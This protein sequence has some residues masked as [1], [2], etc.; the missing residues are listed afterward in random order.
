MCGRVGRS[1]L[2]AMCFN[3]FSYDYI[4]ASCMSI[5]LYCITKRQLYSTGSWTQDY[6]LIH[7]GMKNARETSRLEI[8][9]YNNITRRVCVINYYHTSTL[10]NYICAVWL[11]QWEKNVFIYNRR[12]VQAYIILY[13]K[14]KLCYW[15]YLNYFRDDIK[16]TKNLNQFILLFVIFNTCNFIV[17]YSNFYTTDK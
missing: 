1:F 14:K 11:K 16:F 15:E 8:I 5:W 6:Y 13:K 4:V 10:L 3:L 17:D 7:L 12:L 2:R 9:D